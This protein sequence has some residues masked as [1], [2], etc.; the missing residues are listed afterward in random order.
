MAL[1]KK[2]WTKKIVSI[3]AGNS[4][5]R[6]DYFAFWNNFCFCSARPHQEKYSKNDVAIFLN[7]DNPGPGYILL[8]IDLGLLYL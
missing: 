2:V 1:T 8:Q 3:V 5:R 6:R 4:G 7:Y